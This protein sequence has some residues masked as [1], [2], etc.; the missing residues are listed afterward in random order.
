MTVILYTTPT[1]HFCSA[2]KQFLQQHRVAF[3]ECD[4]S[5]DR[6]KMEEIVRRTGRAS[7]PVIEIDGDFIVG[8][9]KQR[10]IKKLG[11]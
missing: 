6:Q 2:A 1:C 10:L 4:L 8:F 3:V 5:K 9:D 7:V 11:M